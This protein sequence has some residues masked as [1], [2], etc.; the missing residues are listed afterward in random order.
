MTYGSYPLTPRFAGPIAVV[1][2][3]LALGACGGVVK[4]STSVLNFGGVNVGVLRTLQIHVTYTGGPG[5]T[6]R[7]SLKAPPDLNSPRGCPQLHAK[8]GFRPAA[9]ANKSGPHNAGVPYASPGGTARLGSAGAN[10]C[11]TSPGRPGL[12]RC[13]PVTDVAPKGVADTD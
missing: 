10:S 5:T 3:L 9:H 1:V 12:S 11:P 13:G 8:G 4:S 7:V 6:L 2:L